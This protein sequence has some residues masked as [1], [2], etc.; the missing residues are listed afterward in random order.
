[1]S[2]FSVETVDGRG[3]CVIAR[4]DFK[5]GELIVE[6][7]PYGMVISQAYSDVTCGYC[8]KLCVNGTV[9]A[10]SQED[11][12]KYCSESCIT[13]DY[14][15]HSKETDAFRLLKNIQL[16]NIN[17]DSLKLILRCA[18]IRATEAEEPKDDGDNSKV[19]FSDVLGLEAVVSDG[20]SDAE[21][22][23]ITS[24]VDKLTKICKIRKLPLDSDEIKSLLFAIQCNAHRLTDADNQHLALGLFPRISM[25]NH[26]CVPNCTHYFEFSSGTKPKMI[27]RAI[28][29]I[30][31]GDEVVYSYVPLYQTTANRQ[32]QLYTAY[33]F[34]C[35]CA[36]C[37]AAM[38]SVSATGGGSF[39]C[40]GQGDDVIEYAAGGKH[41][42]QLAPLKTLL[43]EYSSYLASEQQSTELTVAE[44][45]MN[46]L[47][48]ALQTVT[49]GAAMSKPAD[50]TSETASTQANKKNKSVVTISTT[51]KYVLQTYVSISKLASSVAKPLLSVIASYDG[52]TDIAVLIELLNQCTVLL[53]TSVLFGF[54]A[55][56]CIYKH[57]Q[58]VELEAVQ[59]E[60]LL[61]VNLQ[62]LHVLLSSAAECM[63]DSNNSADNKTDTIASG[64]DSLD[65]TKLSVADAVDDNVADVRADETS[66]FAQ[67]IASM[68]VSQTTAT[69]TLAVFAADTDLLSRWAELVKAAVGSVLRSD[70]SEAEGNT[71]KSLNINNNLEVYKYLHPL[72]MK[73]ASDRHMVCRNTAP[74]VSKL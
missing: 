1:M 25:I 30:A 69:T 52:T 9:Y 74:D 59:I 45:W 21:H 55:L 17:M 42:T 22:T 16:T 71:L 38:S 13:A 68:I 40:E 58:T 12:V 65:M 10:L 33:G 32:K 15:Q 14:P 73:Y 18:A 34:H 47:L 2:R 53:H 24:L 72:M 51:N 27:I 64:V 46:K 6:E 11:S 5:K 61:A 67:K 28:T 60:T 54:L 8:A 70:V 35:S 43:S 31:S 44:G 49:V 7:Q 48:S 57:V 63:N 39:G 20:L 37:S 66:F 36:K 41:D 50:A 56:G 4:D 3:R 19:T 23:E 29:D 62:R 26:S